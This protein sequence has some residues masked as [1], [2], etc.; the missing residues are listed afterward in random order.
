MGDQTRHSYDLVANRYAV[1]LRDELRRK[2]LDR[3]ML[4]AFAEITEGGLVAD[5]GCGP[6]H[7]A[8]YLADRGLRTVGMDLSPA[9]CANA[10]VPTCAADLTALP[11][12]PGALAGL[13]CLYA[14]I[15]L[16][17]AQRAAAY[18]EFA[19]VLRPGGHALISFHT[20]DAEVPVGG[21]RQLSDWWGHDVDL[22][23]RFLDPA[24]ESRMLTAAGLEVIA[25]LDRS[26][27][28]GVE[29]ASQRCTLLAL[30]P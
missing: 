3:A 10:S 21:T 18:E 23:F 13:V 15:H 26:P 6:G 9:M 16:G 22:T 29:H 30:R 24:E 7:V 17:P 19:R 20:S 14:V 2:P 4:D 25:R 11:I 28:P 5:L 27:H 12:R 1:E 8:A